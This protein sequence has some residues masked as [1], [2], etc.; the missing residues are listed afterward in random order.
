M[1]AA[2]LTA[3]QASAGFTPSELS[4]LLLSALFALMLLWSVWA[5]STAYTGWAEQRLSQ[6]QFFAVAV[7]VVALYLALTFF[8]LS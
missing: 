6:R 1:T 2:Q 5:L 4:W 7:R 8:L 3:F